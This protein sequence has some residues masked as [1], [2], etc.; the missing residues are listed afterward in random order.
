MIK[1]PEKLT[2]EEEV[3]RA[4]KMGSGA[5]AG[6]GNTA[7]ATDILGFLGIIFAADKSGATL[8]FSQISKLIARLRYVKVDY[9]RVFG[10]FLSELG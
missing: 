9:G 6:M 5:A 7:T 4:S 1:I 2:Q 3:T 10:K 8:K